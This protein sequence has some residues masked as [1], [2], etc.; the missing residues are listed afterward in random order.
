FIEG[1]EIFRMSDF[2]EGT[3]FYKPLRIFYSRRI[4]KS[5]N[6]EVVP[7][8]GGLK[9]T[10]K[11]EK[12]NYGIFGVYTEEV[13]DSNLVLEPRRGFGVFRG[14]YKVLENS[15]MGILF[16]GTAVNGDAYNYAIGVDGVYR[17]GPSQLI[18]Q[19]AMSDKIGKR[20]WAVSS[21][22]FGFIKSFLTMGSLQVIG[23]SFDVGDIGYVPW[24]GMKKFM[25]FTGPY[26]TYPTGFLRN[27]WTGLG[28]AL[29]QDPGEEEWSKIGFFNFNFN[30][31]SNWGA[32]L[33][34]EGGPYYDAD[35]NF[36][37]RCTNLSVWGNGPRYNI[38]GGA[39]V[40]YS[41][42][43]YRGFLAYQLNSW[44]GFYWTMMPRVSVELN[45]NLWVEWD[46]LNT[47]IAIWPS[48]T[49]RIDITITPTMTFGIFN[50]FVFNTPGMDFGKTEYLSNRFG[51]LFSYNFKPKSW[52]YIA[53]NDY[54]KNQGQGLAL[55]NQVGAI[56][57]KYLIYF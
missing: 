13:K 7:I 28:G 50:E 45:S 16:S 38:W 55:Q 1:S 6:N 5:I 57:A 34:F 4:G 47:I 19:G 17:S 22:Y 42:N 49:P 46:T 3:G 40:N 24:T 52:L 23:D 51:F 10:S 2:G 11:S 12:L 26:I 35:T 44:Y 27:F 20:D 56:K 9:L 36:L 31:R 53:L 14:K 39:N 37:F 54:R 33:E 18:I 32:S 48:A 15:D 41:Y 21:G 29:V 43:Y 8:I 30:F 25:L